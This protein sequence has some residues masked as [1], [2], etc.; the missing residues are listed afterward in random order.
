LT[1][2]A[3]FRRCEGGSEV[4]FSVDMPSRQRAILA[5][6]LAQSALII[7]MDRGETLTC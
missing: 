5:L 7:E 2:K 6:T 3:P 1:A 4:V